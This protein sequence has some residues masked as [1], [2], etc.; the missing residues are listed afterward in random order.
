MQGVFI[1]RD[2]DRFIFS[3]YL[4]IRCTIQMGWVNRY[5]R[6][7]SKL[8]I[9]EYEKRMEPWIYVKSYNPIVLFWKFSKDVYFGDMINTFMF[10]FFTNADRRLGFLLTYHNRRSACWETYAN[11]RKSFYRHYSPFFKYVGVN[12]SRYDT[13]ERWFSLFPTE[14][15]SDV[16]NDVEPEII[17]HVMKKIRKEES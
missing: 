16:L 14:R 12:I 11:D 17:E 9:S 2:V 8:Q 13:I 10:P 7:L 5:F 6:K 15:T 4:T 3:K 1:H